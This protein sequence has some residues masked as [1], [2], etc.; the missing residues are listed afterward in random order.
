[1]KKVILMLL[2]LVL[3]G[4]VFANYDCY[5]RA[6]NDFSSDS[7]AFQVYSDDAIELYEERPEKA[8]KAAVSELEGK[9]E[10]QKGSFELAKISCKEVVPGN[11]ISRVCYVESQHGYFFISMDMMEQLN[12]VFNRWD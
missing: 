5:R 11:F 8:V 7:A 2:A 1:M 3:S 9:L 6:L 4:S 12:I 10:C